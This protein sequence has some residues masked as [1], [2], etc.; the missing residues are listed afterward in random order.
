MY[1][2]IL[3]D[4]G[5]IRRIVLKEI[6]SQY[7]LGLLYAKLV[8]PLISGLVVDSLILQFNAS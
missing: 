4:F 1:Q 2:R 8:T 6:I 5:E 3:A 7:T